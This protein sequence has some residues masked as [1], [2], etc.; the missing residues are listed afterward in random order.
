MGGR[1]TKMFEP[2]PRIMRDKC[3]GCGR[4]FHSC[5]RHTIRMVVGNKRR[6]AKID[7]KNC[8]RC[9]CCQE[10][11]PIGAVGVK[12]NALIRLIH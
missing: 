4:C 8:I 12:Q 7:P 2:R 1:F 9:W 3:V 10:L 11:C 6:I 5:P